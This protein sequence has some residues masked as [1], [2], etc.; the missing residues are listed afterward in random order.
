[1]AHI[2]PLRP[3]GCKV[4]LPDHLLMCKRHWYMVP[5]DLRYAVTD[6]YASGAGLGSGALLHAQQAAIDAVRQK[7]EAEH[8]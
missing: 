7:L 4:Q 5:R 1:M 8:A 6:A 3:Q 2:C